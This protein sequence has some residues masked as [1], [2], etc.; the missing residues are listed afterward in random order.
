VRVAVVGAGV[1]GLV[2]A[3]E[4][5]RAHEVVLLERAGRAGGHAHTVEVEEPGIGRF[6]V[7]LGFLVYNEPN[8]PT[9]TRLFRELGVETAPSSMSFAVHD[10][11]SGFLLSGDRLGGLLARRRNL[12]DRRFWAIALGQLRFARR[13]RRALRAGFDGTIAEFARSAGLP[14]EFVQLYLLPIAGAI[15]S[16]PPG[17]I[18]DFPAATLLRFFANHGLLTLLDR[19]AWR[20]VAGGSRRYVERLVE[21]ARFQLVTGA[22]VER[23]RRSWLGGVELS[24]GGER[25]RFDRALLALHSDQ[26]LALLAEPTAAER[27]IL[28]AIRYRE[29]EA[30]LHDDPSLLPPPAG[31]ASWNVRLAAPERDGAAEK[32]IAITYLLNKLQPLPAQRPWCVTLNRAAEIDPAR[33]RQR[34]VFAHPQFDRAAIAAQA[35]WSEIDG[36]G[37]VHYAGAYWRYGF[38]EDG[39]W[40]GARAAQALA[41]AAGGESGASGSPS[42]A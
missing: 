22:A 41:A 29:N 19:P 39:A 33:V 3:R 40:S 37:G 34:V 13:G 42:G 17:R 20:T 35:R 4:L 21:S 9:L 25:L 31:R 8:Y 36:T 6:A 1:A 15:W 2:A 26:A 32:G 11:A 28:G 5:A 18:L 27:E 30:V 10:P 14:W 16:M 12:V 23:L 24:V 38:H 7:D